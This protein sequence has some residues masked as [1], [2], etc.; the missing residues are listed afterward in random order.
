MLGFF[1]A[2]LKKPGRSFFAYEMI[3][4]IADGKCRQ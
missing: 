1:I 3:M 2:D 4:S